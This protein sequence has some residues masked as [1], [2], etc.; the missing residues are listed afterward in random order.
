[1]RTFRSAV[2]SPRAFSTSRYLEGR[3][4]KALVISR[5]HECLYSLL[6]TGSPYNSPARPATLL[7]VRCRLCL[8]MLSTASRAMSG[9]LKAI[10]WIILRLPSRA[11]K[12]TG[13]LV[14]NKEERKELVFPP[15]LSLSLS[16]SSSSSLSRSFS[17]FLRP[18]HLFTRTI[19]ASFSVVYLR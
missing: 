4:Q 3:N 16:S 18:R 6:T 14:R 1:M 15:P 10:M 19:V 13:G 9:I 2:L 11:L 8:S 7:H 12:T 17:L 5:L